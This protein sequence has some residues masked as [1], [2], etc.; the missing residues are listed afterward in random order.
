MSATKSIVSL[1]IGRLIDQGKIKS[2]HQLVSDFFLEWKQGRKRLITIRHLLNHTSGLDDKPTTQEIYHSPDYVQFALV[3]EVAADPGSRFFDSNKA[4]NLL[5][6]VALRASDK[7]LDEYI[8]REIFLRPGYHRFRVG[9]RSFR[10]SEAQ[11]RAFRSPP[12]TSPRSASSCSTKA[13][14]AVAGS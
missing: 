10:Q 5:A 14:G 7:P 6:V 9:E 2:R 13:S 4:T 11:W 3:V 12:S 8:K 1:A